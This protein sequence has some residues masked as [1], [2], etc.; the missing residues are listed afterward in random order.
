LLT[1]G[2]SSI[3]KKIVLVMVALLLCSL[4]FTAC[5]PNNT[6]IL[7]TDLSQSD[8]AKLI[9]PFTQKTGIKVDIM[10]FGSADS[11]VNA[12]SAASDDRG[13]G[14]AQSATPKPTAN[15]KA[16]D[17]VL[18]SGL[19]ALTQLA[20]RDALVSYM[21]PSVAD[22][23]YGVNGGGYWYG[24]GGKGWVIAW[25]T[26]L[27]TKKPDSFQDLADSA[28]PLKSVTLPNPE[29]YSYYPLAAY[30]VMGED[31]ALSIFQTMILNEA[32]F[33]SSPLQAASSVATGSKQVVIT[34]YADA[35]AQKNKGAP[36]DFAFPDQG[37]TDMGAYV[38]FYS[39][40]LPTGG[41][42]LKGAKQLDDWL[43]STE[44]EALSV[45]IGLSDITLRDVG[46][47]A[48]VVKPLVVSP[49]DIIAN[50]QQAADAFARLTST[51]N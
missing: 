5:E 18:T 50:Q 46:G 30:S 25:N 44:A 34:T 35:K 24:F 39:V 7:Y 43:L 13:R 17:V 37:K 14:P 3:V 47:R 10:T 16:P 27:V 23:P 45:T 20:Q 9:A 33:S 2:R 32:S 28:Y 6:L 21:S 19:L 42:F 41:H 40:G 22:L 12:I 15:P 8:A 36:I 49:S 26:D 38:E 1:G 29:Q 51:G 4:G 48:P 31:Y 11:L